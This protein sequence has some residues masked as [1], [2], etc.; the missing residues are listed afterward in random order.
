M[1]ITFETKSGIFEIAL[2]EDD[3]SLLFSGL[4]AGLSLPYECATGTCGTCRARVMQGEVADAWSEAPAGR[5][6]KREKGD[7]LMCQSRLKGPCVVRVPAQVT[8]LV[9]GAPARLTAS[10]ANLRR[11]TAD[12][13]E[14]DAVLPKPI[15][16]EAG[17]FMVV[18]TPGVQG[19]RAYSMVNYA[20]ETN[21]LRFVV[22]RKPDGAFSDWL[23]ES[24]ADGAP[25]SLFG[26]LG[27]A[28]LRPQTDGDLVCIT[29]GSGIAGIMSIL[30]HAVTSGHFAR[31]SGELY[32]GVRTTADI[33]YADELAA[34][35]NAV[36]G[37]LKVTI[38]LS[39]EAPAETSHPAS[40]HVG[41]AEGF[42]H[43]VAAAALAARQTAPAANAVGFVAGPPPMVDAAIRIL[44][45]GGFTPGQVRYDKFG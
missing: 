19:G 14:F 21:R 18:T 32:F 33:F 37:A 9:A 26:P 42:V 43:D 45:G 35:A 27:K 11:L 23:F 3:E 25:L 29:G 10:I 34:M 2:P 30:D 28:T 41:L 16:F 8:E 38:A 22:K 24:A 5:R 31:N 36:G 39:H 4:A 13:L 1:T 12:V 17:Q 6:L 40:P 15:G 44:L 20:P 7:V